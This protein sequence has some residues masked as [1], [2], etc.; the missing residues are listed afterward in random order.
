M[1]VQYPA[2]PGQT[3]GIMAMP[4]LN[5]DCITEQE[6]VMGTASDRIVI[7]IHSMQIQPAF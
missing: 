7:S 1:I 6:R 2:T 3:A 5:E 4:N